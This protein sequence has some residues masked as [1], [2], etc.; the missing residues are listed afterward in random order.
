MRLGMLLASIFLT[1][2]TRSDCV[3]LLRQFVLRVVNLICVYLAFTFNSDLLSKSCES[4]L[5]ISA[6]C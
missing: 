2:P 6:L 5:N 4:V 1:D 3:L